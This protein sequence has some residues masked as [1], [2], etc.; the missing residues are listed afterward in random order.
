[1]SDSGGSSSFG[2][3][4][5]RSE[6]SNERRRFA[7]NLVRLHSQEC[8]RR[9]GRSN[10]D[11][12]TRFAKADELKRRRTAETLPVE[13]FVES[14]ISFNRRPRSDPRRSTS[15]EW[16][17]DRRADLS[18]DERTQRSGWTSSE[19]HVERF[20]RRES[21]P[22]TSDRLESTKQRE[23][24]VGRFDR[25]I[26]VEQRLSTKV[27]QDSDEN[28]K[29]N[30]RN[31]QS[32]SIDAKRRKF[33][34]FFCFQKIEIE[35]EKFEHC[36]A[37]REAGS[38]S[39]LKRR[40]IRSETTNTDGRTTSFTLENDFQEVRTSSREEKRNSIFFFR[41]TETN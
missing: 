17:D 22:A 13:T 18:A 14:T 2:L 16:L 39:P 41:G 40:V 37:R 3:S 25:R 35:E 9:R 24:S 26:R 27:R 29:T 32:S 28:E 15:E 5:H 30:R 4:T 1:M 23:F 21:F 33:L 36:L 19:N 31:R 6:K 12:R 38:I 7:V 20:R 8:S 11:R 10:S 34:A